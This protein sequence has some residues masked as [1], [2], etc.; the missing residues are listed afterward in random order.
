MIQRLLLCVTW[1][2]SLQTLAQERRQKKKLLLSRII[3]KIK[4]QD[5]YCH[6]LVTGQ[7]VTLIT[8]GFF[9]GPC[10]SVCGSIAIN[11][12]NKHRK[13]RERPRSLHN[14]SSVFASAQQYKGSFV[15]FSFGQQFSA[16]GFIIS[17]QSKSY[18]ITRPRKRPRTC[19]I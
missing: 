16:R 11:A 14:T 12:Q 5:N 19:K 7:S 1:D 3:W 2:P 17:F 8:C 10:N 4:P 9:S 13:N 18:S 6:A 15:M